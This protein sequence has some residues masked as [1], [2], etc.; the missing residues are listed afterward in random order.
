M[1]YIYVFCSSD[2]DSGDEDSEETIDATEIHE[3]LMDTT[4]RC[5]L[6]FEL[7]LIWCLDV[8]NEVDNPDGTQEP[9]LTTE[10]YDLFIIVLKCVQIICI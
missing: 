6:Y 5:L 2:C 10:G 3:N 7:W 9:M 8:G 4:T 1:A